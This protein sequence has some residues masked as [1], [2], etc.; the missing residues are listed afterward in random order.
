MKEF[1]LTTPAGRKLQFLS[2]EEMFKFIR[3][4]GE[5]DGW[6]IHVHWM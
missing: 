3:E 2:L 1:S 5:I 6:V 4:R